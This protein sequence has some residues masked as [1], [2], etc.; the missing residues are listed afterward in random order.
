MNEFIHMDIDY[1]ELIGTLGGLTFIRLF[2]S[3]YIN[4]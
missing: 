4:W 2:E 3:F 1:N